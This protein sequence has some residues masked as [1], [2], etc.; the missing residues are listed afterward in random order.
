MRFGI[1]IMGLLASSLV[2][3]CGGGA[4]T[5][6]FTTWGEDYIETQIPAEQFEDGWAITYDKFLVNIGHVQVADS[7]GTE[8]D[9][10]PGTLLFDH[11]K[12]GVKSVVQFEDL[13]AR[14][15]DHVSYQIP[16]ATAEAEL[17]GSATAADKD[18]MVKDKAAVHVDGTAEKGGQSITFHW[19]FP[20]STLFD[21]CK[22]DKDGKETEG[23]LVTNGGTDEIQLTIHGDHLF[24]DDLQSANAKLRF[25][26]IAGADADADGE[27]TLEELFQVKLVD[28]TAGTYGTGSAAN[29]NDL[30]AFVTALSRTVGHYRGEG[31]CFSTNVP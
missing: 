14:G 6:S 20:V 8:G 11:K 21:N 27:V 31:E 23:A 7:D 4:G 18:L 26:P 5:V 17:D 13:D 24:Y 16:A 3:G 29:V 19:S 15:W 12:K 28:I 10:M 1:F 30:G 22:G 9:A 2:A 25:D